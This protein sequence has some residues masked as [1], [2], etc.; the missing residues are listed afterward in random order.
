M[1]KLN[2]QIHHAFSATIRAGVLSEETGIKHLPYRLGDPACGPDERDELWSRMLQGFADGPREAWGSVI[3]ERLGPALV[4]ALGSVLLIPPSHDR[5]DVAQQ[6]VAEVFEAASE[7]P[8]QPARWSP[9]RLITRATTVLHRWIESEYVPFEVG[10]PTERDRRAEV[11]FDVAELRVDLAAADVESVTRRELLGE[12]HAERGMRL[13]ISAN[14]APLRRWPMSRNRWP[15]HAATSS[16]TSISAHDLRSA[17][18]GS[19]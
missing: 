12:S 2:D 19:E 4:A 15:I 10:L 9:N 5:D 1:L 16:G 17:C 11:G 7:G 8:T 6:L 18:R 14:A 13:G 3:L